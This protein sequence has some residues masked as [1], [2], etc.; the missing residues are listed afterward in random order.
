MSEDG[1]TLR[2]GGVE[3]PR[4]PLSDAELDRLGLP[5][6]F[7]RIEDEAARQ[8]FVFD[9]ALKHRSHAYRASDPEFADDEARA[10]WRDARRTAMDLVLAAI[11][12]SPWRDHLVLRG[13]VLLAE[14]FGAA[15][16]EPKDLDFVVVPR[17][18]RIEEDRT[19]E[20]LRDIPRLAERTAADASRADSPGAGSPRADSPGGPH[21][22]DAGSV[23]PAV[24]FDAGDAVSE[25]IWTYDRVPGR[26]LV[27]PWTCPGT[28]GGIVQLDVVF[29]ES[30]PVA[31]VATT[32][33]GV[34]LLGAT[35]ELSLAWKLVWLA[36]DMHPQGKDLYD[37]VLLAEHC[38]LDYATL[39]AVFIASDPYYAGTPVTPDVTADMSPDYEWRHFAAEYPHLAGDQDDLLRRLRWA[40]EP[41]F[42]PLIDDPRGARRQWSAQW[43]DACRAAYRDGGL[44]A[45]LADLAEQKAP[46]A[47]A[48][49][50]VR[51]LTGGAGPPATAA[52]AVDHVLAHPA[53]SQRADDFSAHHPGFRDR[54]IERL[55]EVDLGA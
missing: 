30:L 5:R 47:V 8:R 33:A 2:V 26:R 6:T 13:S 31:P 29:N 49:A 39:G 28:P 51:D 25:D 36:Q 1:E 21:P 19:G 27:L 37:A 32:V 43:L 42:R 40:L 50:A 52:A 17:D 9:P 35:P 18:W 14:W 45:L 22:Q 16:R 11:A 46:A 24:R 3:V 38:T 12:G 15:A 53:W 55:A 7:R 34:R 41:T 4:T 44:S 23:R 10:A 48:A 20:L 54:L